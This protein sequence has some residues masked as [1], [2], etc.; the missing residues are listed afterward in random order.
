VVI[1]IQP[2]HRCGCVGQDE[3]A[4]GA[5]SGEDPEGQ[6]TE[7]PL[8]TKVTPSAIKK[9]KHVEF[10]PEHTHPYATAPDATY[11]P[12]TE[13]ARSAAREPAA[14]QHEP[15]YHNTAKVYDLQIA[16]AVYE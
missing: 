14:G 5:S 8:P 4:G 16:K 11:T 7:P 13:Q 2:P 10:A 6:D 3:N 1:T 9:G 15:G 12:V